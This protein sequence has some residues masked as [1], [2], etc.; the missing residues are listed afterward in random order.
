MKSL[1][2][3]WAIAL[4]L[5][6]GL[7]AQNPKTKATTTK[8]PAPAATANDQKM[9]VEAFRDLKNEMEK[10]RTLGKSNTEIVR[11][12]KGQ[13][14]SNNKMISQR[15]LLRGLR[16]T[17]TLA[18]VSG[19]AAPSNSSPTAPPVAP[20][21]PAAVTGLSAD[22]MSDA[23]EIVQCFAPLNRSGKLTAGDILLIAE[24]FQIPSLSVFLQILDLAGEFP[25]A[26]SISSYADIIHRAIEAEIDS[27][28]PV[29]ARNPNW[30][31][32]RPFIQLYLEKGETALTAF[33]T[34]RPFDN[35]FGTGTRHFFNGSMEAQFTGNLL[36]NTVASVYGITDFD[37]MRQVV[38]TD[39]LTNPENPLLRVYSRFSGSDSASES[40]D[41]WAHVLKSDTAPNGNGG[42][43][44]SV[45]SADATRFLVAAGYSRESVLEAIRR[46]YQ[47]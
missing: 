41:F 39:P 23:A 6:V 31:Q 28:A 46:V 10:Q 34:F 22:E 42:T 27:E 26:R 45:S 33:N 40:A 15:D 21:P 47:N 29:I 3:Q 25:E 14:G 5:P 38:E 37:L 43:Y 24:E 12:L 2:F 18:T 13:K 11:S 32:L 35:M 44:P 19:F 20:P 7:L 16:K 9:D 30:K 8:A 1:L 4:L 17:T 36:K